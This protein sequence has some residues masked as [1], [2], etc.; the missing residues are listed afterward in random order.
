MAHLWPQHLG[1]CSKRIAAYLRATSVTEFQKEE[2]EK[3]EEK[4]EIFLED[5]H[6]AQW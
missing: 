6:V 2:E 4:E 3:E 5:G 1:D